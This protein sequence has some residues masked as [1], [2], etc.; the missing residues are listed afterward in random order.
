MTSIYEL[1]VKTNRIIDIGERNIVMVTKDYG[2]GKPRFSINLP[3]ERNDLWQML[4][5]RRVKVKV[6]IEI[7]EEELKRVSEEKVLRRA[8]KD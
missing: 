4:W 6:F 1:M 8:S 3:I 5:E 2:R 7:P